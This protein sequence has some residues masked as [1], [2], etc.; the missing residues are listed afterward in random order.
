MPM[1]AEDQFIQNRVNL[2]TSKD[3]AGVARDIPAQIRARAFFSARVAEAH[4]LE[5]FRR[6]SDDYNTGKIGRDEA[7][8]LMMEYARAS[9]K[10][11]GTRGLRNLASTARLNLIIDQNASMAHAVGEYERMYS[12]SALR[13]FPY[14]RYEASVGSKKP[15]GSHQKYDGMIFEKSDPWLRTHWPPWDFGCHCQLVQITAKQ[16][17]KTPDM[18]Q[19][20]TPAD[21][22]KVEVASGFA[23]DPRDGF[24]NNAADL[25]PLERE[26]VIR[27]IETAVRKRELGNVGIIVRSAKPGM[28]PVP[29]PQADAARDCIQKAQ[30]VAGSFL[31]RCGIDIDNVHDEEHFK[32]VNRELQTYAKEK[33][34]LPK[35]AAKNFARSIPQE[36]M[37]AIP[38]LTIPMGTLHPEFA[39]AACLEELPI[40]LEKGNGDFGITHLWRDH[41]DLFIDPTKASLILQETLGWPECRVV[42]SLKQEELRT[43]QRGAPV[44]LCRKKIVLHNPK[45]RAYLVMR[46]A[47]DERSLQIV[48]FN[49]AP[50]SYGTQQWA[51]E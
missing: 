20:P 7:R 27:Q 36:V 10:D 26:S 1:N 51:L 39:A 38:D 45:T 28:K 30:D 2:P 9:G 37:D 18:I 25:E 4:I 8:A 41:K 6:I 35:A 40:T 23:F 15:R 24:T 14:V 29:L 44:L 11:D 3:S 19:A 17:G 5:R 22:V 42:M 32:A 50:E 43:L 34:H 48:S 12:P 21:K 31:M 13:V 49:R 33:L 16:A 46:L 47:E